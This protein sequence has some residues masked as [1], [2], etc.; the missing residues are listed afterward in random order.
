MTLLTPE[1]AQQY[2]PLLWSHLKKCLIIL[3]VL[4]QKFRCVQ[5]IRTFLHALPA[6]QTSLNLFH[7]LLPFFRKPSFLRRSS[8]HQTHPCAVVDLDPRRAWHAVSASSA[9][10]SGKLFLIF[11]N[12]LKKC[13]VKL[14][15]TGLIGQ[16]LIQLGLSLHTPDRS[17]MRKLRLRH[18]SIRSEERR[19]G[20]ECRSRWSPYH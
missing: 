10:I 15:R 16:E 4:C 11:L 2:H 12:L 5:A 7:L 8:E 18:I 13:L 14:W 19:V 6:V 1:K 3:I 17:Y 20:K 9:E